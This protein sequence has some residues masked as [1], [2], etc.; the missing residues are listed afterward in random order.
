[1][2]DMT[3]ADAKAI[4]AALGVSTKT[5]TDTFGRTLTVIDEE[6]MRTLAA[7]SPNPARGQALT[8]QIMAAAREEYGL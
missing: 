5:I 6:G 4:C 2:T 1:M 7:H 8:D 3:D